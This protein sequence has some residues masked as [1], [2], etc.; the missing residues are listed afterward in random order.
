L[1]IEPIRP[2]VFRL[3]LHAQELSS[4]VAAARWVVEG[5]EGELPPEAR[6]QLR[7][8]LASYDEQRR[9]L[10]RQEEGATAT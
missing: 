9:S 7:T 6:E 1:R 8:V 5:A 10:T 4:L 3:T 2:A